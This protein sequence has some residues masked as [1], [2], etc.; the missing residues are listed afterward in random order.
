MFWRK[1]KDAEAGEPEAGSGQGAAR[2]RPTTS[3]LDAAYEG[4]AAILRALGRHAFDLGDRSADQIAAELEAWATH[5]LVQAPAPGS[6]REGGRPG[7]DWRALS[8]FVEAQR[9]A[10]NAYIAGTTACMRETMVAL[11]RS[12]RASSL[13]QG[14][15]DGRI[16][17]ELDKLQRVTEAGSVE[18]L[19]RCASEV[20]TAIHGALEEQRRAGSTETSVLRERLASLE[21]KL[22]EAQRDTMTDALTQLGNRRRFDDFLDRAAL[23]AAVSGQ[24]L[25]VVI[26]DIDHFKRI[27]DEYGHP[28]GDAV[29]K[30]VA[31][32]LVRSFPR[33]SDVVVRYGGEEFAVVLT[34]T[35]AADAR[36]LSL[37][38]LD[39]L[40]NTSFH[41]T[42]DATL[43]IT[44]SGGVA[45]LGPLETTED[46]VRRADAALYAAKKAGRDRV[47]DSSSDAAR[48]A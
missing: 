9:R 26:F 45:E 44:A 42:R 12:L 34:D 40:R 48:A 10:E 32:V 13:V 1:P 43:E 24:P 39:A 29:L 23:V 38:F 20:V 18:E 21:E 6:T 31:D 5:V 4:A 36:R 46:V 37:R 33:R 8:R 28:T 30:V 22:A 19:R 11:L 16:R 2:S 7:R 25:T 27:N 17:G 14:R 35:R 47:V 3:D 15:A 41:P